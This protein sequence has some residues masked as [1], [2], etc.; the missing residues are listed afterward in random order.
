[1]IDAIIKK[2]CNW[3]SEYITNTLGYIRKLRQS[4]STTVIVRRFEKYKFTIFVLCCIEIKHGYD[5]RK[6]SL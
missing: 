6:D 5:L 3:F 2:I 4:I 1:M